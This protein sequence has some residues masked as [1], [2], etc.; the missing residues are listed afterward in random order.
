[1]CTSFYEN[2]VIRLFEQYVSKCKL[3]LVYDTE[4]VNGTKGDQ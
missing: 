1:M 3:D 4:D 2:D